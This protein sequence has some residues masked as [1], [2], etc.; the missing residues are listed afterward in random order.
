MKQTITLLAI[1]SS[2]DETAASVIV[3]GKIL[4]NFIANQTVHEKYGGVVPEL[5]SRAHM[6]NIVPVV[7]AALKKAFPELTRNQQLA[8]LNAI[9]FTQAPGLIG[10][11][12]VG[13]Q[14]AKSMA[15]ALNIPLIAVHHMQAHVL[16]NLIDDPKPNYPFL[17]L[18][19]SGGHTQIVKCNSASEMQ[20]LGET[21][22][23]AAGEAFDKISKL[24]GLPYPGGP[25]LDKLAQL[26]NPKAFVFAKP[27]VPNLDFSFSGLK[28]SVLYFL[29]KQSPEF[30]K[31]NLN[32]LC[33]SVQFTIIE[34]LLKKLK[35]AMQETGIKEVCIA[36]GVS[37][38][39]GLRKAMEQLGKDTK[40]ATFLPKFEYCT[41]NAA[42]IAITAHF[43]YIAGSFEP[44]TTSASAR[45]SWA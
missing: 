2:C 13:A 10:S 19:V 3:D 1:E 30:I 38:N 43:K 35:K 39:S 32:D 15:L 44:L 26:G 11:L 12:L 7:D 8:Q 4:S 40:S 31:E 14:F 42:M 33:A 24:L 41:D 45:S 18:T 21:I 36:G 5:A 22:D 28:T 34:I 20:I 27:Q 9:A 29:Q 25:V 23:D 37:A 17:C 6:E 16:A